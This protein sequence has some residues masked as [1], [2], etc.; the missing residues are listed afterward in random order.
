[1]IDA[2]TGEVI[3]LTK[4]KWNGKEGRVNLGNSLL[5]GIV[6]IINNTYNRF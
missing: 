1:M 4:S 2:E 3:Q 6:Y 5:H